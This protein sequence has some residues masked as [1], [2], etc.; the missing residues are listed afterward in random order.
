MIQLNHAADRE[1][2]RAFGDLLHC[3]MLLLQ[4]SIQPV[5]YRLKIA[6]TFGPIP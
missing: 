1:Q 5:L 4:L 6:S 3:V 2:N